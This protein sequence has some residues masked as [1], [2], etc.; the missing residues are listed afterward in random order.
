[1]R[2]Y[3]LIG[4][5][6]G[7][8]FSKRYFDSKFENESIDAQFENFEIEHIESIVD[9]VDSNPNLEGFCITIPHKEAII[10]YLDELDAVAEEIGAVNCVKITRDGD[11]RTMKGYNTDVIGFEK[12][13]IQHFDKKAHTKALVLGTG[14]ASKAVDYVLGQLGVERYYVSR[15]GREGV[16]TYEDV[17]GEEIVKYPVIVN[18]TPLGMYPKVDNAPAI[19]YDR[20]TANHYLY[21]LVYNPEETL[22]LKNAKQQGADS[23]N[24]MD[25]LEYQAEGAWKVWNNE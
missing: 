22:F 13:F 25:M 12:S 6:L 9:I 15:N 2:K 23:K 21:D 17:Q 19:S 8:S 14:G 1:M 16:L 11:K 24:G 10:P 20:L 4:F 5:P 3:G 7:H 18:T